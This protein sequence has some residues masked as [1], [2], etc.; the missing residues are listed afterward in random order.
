MLVGDGGGST[1][2]EYLW[3]HLFQ[4]GPFPLNGAS[5]IEKGPRINRKGFIYKRGQK[6]LTLDHKPTNVGP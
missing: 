3:C 5:K 4:K 1:M 2:K 6:V